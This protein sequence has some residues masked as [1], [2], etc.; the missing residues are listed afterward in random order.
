MRV[1]LLGGA[2]GPALYTVLVVVCGAL[3]PGYS[4]VGQLI[5]EL[6]ARGTTH[7]GLLNLAGAIPAGALIA[8]FAAATL[9]VL[10]LGRRAILAGCLF[11][12]Y[13]LGMITFG[14][15]P[16]DPGCPSPGPASTLPGTIHSGVALAAS[17]AAVAGI[18]LWAWEFRQRPAFRNLSRFSALSSAAGLAF[19][20]T[21]MASLHS[22]AVIGLWQRLLVGTLFLWCVVVAL[23]LFRAAKG[24]QQAS[25]DG[26]GP[27]AA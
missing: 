12:F 23:R 4:H 19:L 18:G 10:R 3:R 2:L 7:A 21:F 1:L 9:S 27:Y 6:G 16:C 5:S 13:G 20:I 14:I 11:M 25:L 22:R 26:Y 8:G 17:V 24:D 15:V